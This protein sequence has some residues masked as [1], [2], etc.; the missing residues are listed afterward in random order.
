MNYCSLEDIEDQPLNYGKN[1]FPLYTSDG[2]EFTAYKHTNYYL[3]LLAKQL[4][5]D[6]NSNEFRS[7]LQKN[8]DKLQKLIET[9]K[10]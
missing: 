4:K 2:R 6:I 3:E 10:K 7:F 8:P 5:L 1:S 9:D